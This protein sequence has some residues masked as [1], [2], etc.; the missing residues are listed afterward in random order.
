M[1][2][3]RA[4]PRGARSQGR[5]AP[6]AQ[7]LQPPGQARSGPAADSSIPSLQGQRSRDGGAGRAG[8]HA[9]KEV[10]EG[11]ESEARGTAPPCTLRPA[12]LRPAPSCPGVSH[13]GWGQRLVSVELARGG[14][15]LRAQ[16]QV[17]RG[18]GPAAA[19]CLGQSWLPAPH[20]A[21]RATAPPVVPPSQHFT[22]N[23]WDLAYHG[24]SRV[25]GP[26][27][28]QRGLPRADI[29]GLRD[30]TPRRSSRPGHRVPG[31]GPQGCLLAASHL[32][33]L[34]AGRWLH[35]SSWH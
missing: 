9:G 35:L 16:S 31:A 33:P 4:A 3:T 18:A 7:S 17:P 30:A 10:P 1:P 6:A 34:E 32:T 20:R 13:Q 8:A 19:V 11:R 14:T 29:H 15:A 24:R 25:A 26:R 21:C 5:P 27:G 2:G 12:E 22:V 23:S 28:R